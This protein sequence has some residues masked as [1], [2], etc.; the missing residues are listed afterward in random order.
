VIA[1]NIQFT[2]DYKVRLA[3]A[4]EEREMSVEESVLDAVERALRPIENRRRD[5]AK[6]VLELE[7]LWR[8]TDEPTQH[9][10]DD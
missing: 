6:D 7:A 10:S 1:V 2:T 9:K 3:V 4:A 8:G 5:A